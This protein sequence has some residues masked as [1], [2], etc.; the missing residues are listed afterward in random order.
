MHKLILAWVSKK[1]RT[2][3][4]VGIS[5]TMYGVKTKIIAADFSKGQFVYGDIERELQEIPVGILGE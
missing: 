4:L 3:D 1:Y 2:L 5:E